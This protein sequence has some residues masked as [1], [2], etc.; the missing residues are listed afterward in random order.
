[1]KEKAQ[2]FYVIPYIFQTSKY[3]EVAHEFHQLIRLRIVSDLDKLEL[4][5]INADFKPFGVMKNFGMNFITEIATSWGDVPYSERP[6]KTTSET[7]STARA[8]ILHQHA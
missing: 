1:L 4:L 6:K 3:P 5:A 7:L 8:S 2:V